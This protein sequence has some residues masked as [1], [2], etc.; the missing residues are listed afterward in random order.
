MINSRPKISGLLTYYRN[1]EIRCDIAFF[2]AGIIFDI[3]TLSSIDDPFAIIQQVIYLVIIGTFIFL[4]FSLTKTDLKENSM[5]KSTWDYHPLIV[6]FLLG[7]LLS[8]YSLFFIKSASLFSSVFFILMMIS[9]LVFNEMKRLQNSTWNFKWSLFLL[10][11]F[12]FFSMTTPLWMGFVGWTPF[13]FSIACTIGVLAAYN[14]FLKIKIP[15]VLNL[16]RRL[17]IPGV[18]TITLL[19]SFYLLGWI[20]PVPLAATHIG[21]YHHIEK[22]G[23]QYFLAHERPAWKIWH[24]GDQD[25]LAKPG[26]KIYFFAKLYSPSGFKDSVFLHWHFYD[27]KLG[28]SSTDRIPM[29]INGGR[30][31]GYRGYSVKQNYQEGEWKISVET[32]DGREIGRIYLTVRNSSA[33]SKANNS[34]TIK[35]YTIETH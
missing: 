22:K 31:E 30:E 10:C 32:T 14:H 19:F 34:E 8:A 23:D 18:L 21:I 6:H 35:N 4:E 24:S 25:F 26:D 13:L 20:P 5:W 2:V 17:I 28:W 1:N 7:S 16:K 3:F 15:N 12:C 11:V 33:T 9:L 29:A 27:S